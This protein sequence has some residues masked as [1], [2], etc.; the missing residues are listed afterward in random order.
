MKLIRYKDLGPLKGIHY[1]RVHLG[2][3][4]ES[5]KFPKRVKVTD[6]FSAWIESEV[7][8]WIAARVAASRGK[9][10]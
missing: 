1:S 7:D 9:A 3:L 5:G 10:A 6:G 8:D 2:R 4:E